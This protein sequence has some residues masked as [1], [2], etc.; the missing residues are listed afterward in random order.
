MNKNIKD[1]IEY[2]KEGI[3]SKEIIKN[4]KLDMTLFCL[5]AGSEISEHTS[6]KQGVI[7]VL[8]GDGIFNLEGK[9]IKMLPGV[10]IHMKENAVHALK[11]EKN[12]SFILILIK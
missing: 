1:L 4:D 3:F 10:V 8:E 5:A 11:A 2:P 12:T 7:Y 6:T 9:D